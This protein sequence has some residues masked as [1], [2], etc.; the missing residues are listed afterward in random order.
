M[1]YLISFLVASLITYITTPFVRKLAFKIDAIDIPKDNRRIHKKPIPL[2]GG[3]SIYLSNVITYILLI[4]FGLFT[5]HKNIIFIVIASSII[6][7]IGFVDDLKPLS[8]NVKFISEILIAILLVMAGIKFNFNFNIVYRNSIIN[9]SFLSIP[10]SILWIVGITNSINLIDGLDGL[11]SGI[12]G[13][14]SVYLFLILLILGRLDVTNSYILF[15]SIILAGSTIGFLPY[16]FN[17]ANIFMGDMG[18]LYLGFILS[19]ISIIGFNNNP[20]PLIL[21]FPIIILAVPISDTIYAVFRRILKGKRIGDADKSHIHHILIKKGL[22]QKEAALT[23]YL[24]SIILGTLA[25]FLTTINLSINIILIALTSILT[26]LI[27][28]NLY[29]TYIHKIK[30]R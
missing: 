10:L 7:T 17:P 8:C 22:N 2:L 19:I 15:V 23:L 20:S 13:I 25:I 11:A 1:I 24:L 12:S 9:F 29:F 14:S 5:M 28:Y 16:N 6:L 27:L 30:S 4:S 18:A 21:I 26:A 3:L